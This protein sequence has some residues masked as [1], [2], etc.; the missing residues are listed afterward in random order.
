MVVLDTNVISEISGIKP[1]SIVLAW[2]A[3]VPFEDLHLCTPVVAEMSF[4]AE[5]QVLRTGSERHRKNLEVIV[6]ERFH[7]RILPFSLK[8]ARIAGRMRA[9]RERM[10]LAVSAMDMAIAGIAAANNATLATRNVRDFEGLD[11]KLINPFEA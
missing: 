2:T 3:T 11:L 6:G 10:G 8:A 1:N 4:G 7:G 5:R 9:T